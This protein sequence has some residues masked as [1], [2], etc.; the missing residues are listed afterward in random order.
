MK[1]EGIQIS[2]IRDPTLLYVI[3]EFIAHFHILVRSQNPNNQSL[4]RHFT[5][6]PKTNKIH[7]LTSGSKT[8]E[9][10]TLL[11]TWR[12]ASYSC[13]WVSIESRLFRTKNNGSKFNFVRKK[14]IRQENAQQIIHIASLDQDNQTAP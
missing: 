10:R 3:K 4:Y 9:N 7:Y 11:K 8:N 6:F 5:N 1:I 14:V 13:L 2:H 12:K